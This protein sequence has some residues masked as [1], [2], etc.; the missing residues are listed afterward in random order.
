M[1]L[2][3][4][5]NAFCWMLGWA[6]FAFCW[7]LGWA[8]FTCAAVVGLWFAALLGGGEPLFRAILWAVGRGPPHLQTPDGQFRTPAWQFSLHHSSVVP[9][10]RL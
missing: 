4:P 2:P 8:V 5:Q 10:L 9:S 6:S 3:G 7:V 1:G